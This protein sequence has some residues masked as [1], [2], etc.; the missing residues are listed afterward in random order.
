MVNSAPLLN[1]VISR[2]DL[3]GDSQSAPAAFVQSQMTAR[4]QAA[5]R[6]L[7]KDQARE[8]DGNIFYQISA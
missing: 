4:A 7:V 5:R 1:E 6:K 8:K 2:I 3:L